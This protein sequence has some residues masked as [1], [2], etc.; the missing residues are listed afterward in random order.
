MSLI[1]TLESNLP[2]LSASVWCYQKSK[3]ND[4]LKKRF[5]DFCEHQ[6]VQ[7]SERSQVV[8]IQLDL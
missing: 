5:D 8:T 3:K 7:N 4:L 6:Q 2:D 1:S